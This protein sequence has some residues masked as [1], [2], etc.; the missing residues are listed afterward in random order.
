MAAIPQQPDELQ[1]PAPLE[2]LQQDF[3]HPDN[4]AVIEHEAKRWRLL[5]RRERWKLNRYV[6][7]L[8]AKLRKGKWNQQLVERQKL[9]R[10]MRARYR[11]YKATTYL[12]EAAMRAAQRELMALKAQVNHL[13]SNLRELRSTYENL[14]HFGGWLDYERQHRQDLIKESRREKEIRRDMR[15]EA[16]WLEQIMLDVWRKTDGCHYTYKKEGGK[17]VT[18]T[19]KF[20]R[21]I[22]K[23]DSHW[24]YI[25]TSRRVLWGWKWCLPNSVTVQRLMEEDVMKN[26]QAATKRQVDAVWTD[27]HQL[28]MRVSRLDSPDALPSRVMWRDAISFFPEEK[29][30]KLPYTIGVRENRKFIWYDLASEPHVLVAGKSQSGKSNLVN[31][32]IATLVSNR[33]PDELRI[34]LVDQ[35]GGIEFTHWSELPHLLWE[36]CKTV[37][38]VEP[39][40]KRLS[41]VMKRRMSLLERSKAKDIAAYNARVGPNEQLA[42]VLLVIDEM[43]T[44]VGL[45]ALTEEIH[46]LIMLLASQGRAVG[47]HVIAA[48][49]HPEVRVIP[50]RIKTNMAVRLCGFMPTVSASMI[51]LDSPEAS[52][53]AN[54]PGRFVASAGRD[55]VVVQ[56]PMI[57]DADIAGVVAS[58]RRAHPDVANELRELEGLPQLGVWNEQRV[59]KSCLDW[60]DGHLAA[61]KLHKTLGSDSPGERHLRK[62]VRS[63]V[64]ESKAA[65]S[66]LLVEDGTTWILKRR[67]NRWFLNSSN[68]DDSSNATISEAAS[69]L[70]SELVPEP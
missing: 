43:S 57:L 59:I 45:G 5:T 36:M 10:E 31:G 70:V 1:P 41:S 13:E 48:T 23:P 34:V 21:S 47:I 2:F 44:F 25:R 65:G 58:A 33:T 60:F 28:I 51:V 16:K 17:E 24:F 30:H 50:G 18:K 61:D 29:A 27:Q 12:D 20:E 40:L 37:D 14:Q 55:E 62:L 6:N 32:I 49:Q 64:D 9:L 19:P 42:R 4:R 54:I 66:V 39:L 38:G 53:I 26:L 63:I 11:A 8:A 52:R 7:S 3:I 67:G 69:E 15:K 68:S 56:V 22:I 46:N 35:K